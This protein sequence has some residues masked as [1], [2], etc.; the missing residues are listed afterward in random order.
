MSATKRKPA[1][2]RPRVRSKKATGGGLLMGM[3]AGFK[4][5]AG[6]ATAPKAARANRMRRGFAI[7]I[8]VT[9]VIA[10]VWGLAR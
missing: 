2:R 3:R 7:A 1:P 8:G 6:T 5:V 10:L 9:L 4:K